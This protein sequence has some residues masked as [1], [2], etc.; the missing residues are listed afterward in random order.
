MRQQVRLLPGAPLHTAVEPSPRCQ[1]DRL[2]GLAVLGLPPGSEVVKESLLLDSIVIGGELANLSGHRPEVV[3]SSAARPSRSARSSMRRSLSSR[4]RCAQADS[5]IES[6]SKAWKWRSSACRCGRAAVPQ[7]QGGRGVRAELP[8][9]VC[10][11]RLAPGGRVGHPRT[12]PPN[13]RAPLARCRPHPGGQM[14]RFHNGGGGSTCGT[15]TDRHVHAQRFRCT[16]CHSSC[17]A[18]DS[19]VTR[20][21]NEGSER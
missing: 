6:D 19:T 10:R 14:G 12:W 1:E 2:G 17:S 20:N 3:V 21:P 13:L 18:S 5:G 8:R 4:I 16:A 9:R 7:R 15:G 11:H